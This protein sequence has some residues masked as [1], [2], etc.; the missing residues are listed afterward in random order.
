MSTSARATVRN[1]VPKTADRLSSLDP[2]GTVF[3]EFTA[4]ANK[5][6]AVNLG[7]GFP[8]LPVPSF[9]TDAAKDAV[10]GSG[11]MHQY[12]RS[13]GHVRLT[14]ALSSYYTSSLGRTLN[15][16]TEILTAVGACQAIFSTIQ[17][18]INPGDEVIIMQPFYDSYPASVALAGGVPRMVSLRP[19]VGQPAST[20]DE[21]KLDVEEIRKAISPGKTKM[22]IVNNPHNPIGKVF[23]REELLAIAD[24]AKEYDLLVLADEVYETL[25]F[26]D[27][28]EQLIKFAS[29]PGMFE[30]T[31]TVGSAGKMFGVTGWKIG[32]ALGPPELIRAIWMVHQYVPFSVATPLQEATAV[33]LEQAQTNGYFEE[34]RATYQRLRDKLQ[35][36]LVEAGLQPTL[37][38]GGYFTLANTSGIQIP[39]DA[40]EQQEKR[41]DYVVCRYLTR[42]AGITAIPPSAFYDPKDKDGRENV[43]GQLARFAFCKNDEMLEDAGSKLLAFTSRTTR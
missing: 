6:N 20:A 4:L 5:S 10:S 2:G 25:V 23:R 34:T 21:W 8:T 15:P 16:L 26:E 40:A 27:S 41:R 7:Q 31:I 30:R 18:F 9:I 19:P 32:W 14:N 37:P 11:L 24:I 22:I 29:L 3:A 17:A 1:A 35:K 42:E 38:H 33:A 28:V 13:E 39:A 36:I 43:A 12:T